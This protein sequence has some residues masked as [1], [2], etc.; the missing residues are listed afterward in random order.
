MRKEIKHIFD[1][2]IFR[3][4]DIRGIVGKTLTVKDAYFIGY[5][6]AEQIKKQ[7]K[8]TN[9]II[10]YDGRLSSP[11]LE[12]N[13]LQGLYDNEASITRIGL[14]TSPMLYFSLIKL[15]ADGAIMITGSHNPSE[16]NG[17]KILSKEGSYF[18][19]K[20]I[21]LSKVSKISIKK[22]SI[23]NYNITNSYIK[24]L[25][26]AISF[27]ND[28]LTV[29]WDPGN[30]STGSILESFIK[31][32]PGKHILINSKV[33]GT[34]PNHHPDPTEEE[35]LKDIK[36]Y[37]KKNNADVGIAFD[38]DG[39]RIGVLDPNGKLISGDKL[40]LLYAL[41]LLKKNPNANIIGD[42]KASNVIFEEINK[43][44]G[45]AIMS[46]T[47]HSLIKTKMKE[48]NAILAG[49]MS[50]HIFFA[51]Q[52]YGFDDALYAAVRLI[53]II[54][55][56]F[57]LKKFLNK[58]KNYHSTPEIKIFCKDNVKFDIINKIKNIV[59]GRYKD[60]SYIDGI[61]VNLGNSWWLIRASNTQP[62]IIVRCESKSKAQLDSVIK[63]VKSILSSQGLKF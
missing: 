41:E 4:Y 54:M 32:M 46:K 33:D 60:V 28:K 48:T 62:A 29:V 15:K 44:G 35:N 11:T 18:G 26:N 57:S 25:A 21:S 6:F 12:K 56:N 47:G 50:G 31:H 9:I 17:F 58:F 2:S 1:R 34:F 19:K 59:S 63:E 10:G 8:S 40:L 20:I 61:R 30:G 38:G 39:D 53:N 43:H 37:I 24:E 13:L 22:G 42:V 49:E 27:D 36:K 52:Y 23:N 16:Y 3:A 45:K 55:K 51:D 5:N 7:F 14:C